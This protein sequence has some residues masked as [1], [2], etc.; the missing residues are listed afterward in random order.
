MC[1]WGQVETSNN[2]HKKGCNAHA[3]SWNET[4]DKY[5]IASGS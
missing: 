4:N 3:V 5:Q 2:R 1:Q